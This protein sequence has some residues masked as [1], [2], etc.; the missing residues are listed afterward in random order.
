MATRN[1]LNWKDIKNTIVGVFLLKTLLSTKMD[2]SPSLGFASLFVKSDIV[3]KYLSYRN[4]C[5]DAM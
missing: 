2:S 4:L 1:H 5:V 3:C